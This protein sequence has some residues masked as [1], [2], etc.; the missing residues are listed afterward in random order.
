M[1]TKIIKLKKAALLFILLFGVQSFAQTV[2]NGNVTDASGIPLP[3]ANIVIDGTTTGVASDF[4][5][6][7][8]LSTSEKPPF[9]LKVSSVG[10]ETKSVQVTKSNQTLSIVLNDDNTLDEVIISAS[11]KREKIQEAP[12]A[13]S[14]LTSKKMEA[15]ST[16]NPVMGLKNLTGVDVAQYGVGEGKINLRGKSTAF[17]TETFVIADY[18]NVSIPSLGANQYGQNPVDAIDLDRVEVIKGPGSALYGPGVEAG[19]VHFISKSP[20]KKQGLTFSLGLGNQQQVQAAFRYAEVSKNEKLGFKV[21][22]FVRSAEDFEIDDPEGLARISDDA[23][24]IFSS[25]TGENLGISEIPDYDTK[26]YGFTGTL[27]YKIS[28]KTTLVGTGGYSK[29]EGLIRVGQGEG[30]SELPRPFAQIRL[31]SGGFFAQAFWSKQIGGDDTWLYPTGTTQYNDI[32]QYEGQ[33]QYNFDVLDNKLDL[34]VGTDYRLNITDSKGSLYG[35]FEDDDDYTIYG[36]YLQGKYKATDKVDLIAAGR[37]DRFEA[38]EHTSFSPRL[39]VVYKHDENHTFRA[40]Y[41]H[42]TGAP[43]ALNLF[44]DFQ[45]GAAIG[46]T[47][48]VWLNGGADELTY[49]DGNAYILG[50]GLGAVP[51]ELP[52]AGLYQVVAQ[53]FAGSPLEPYI[54]SLLPQIAASGSTTSP[55][56]FGPVLERGKLEP[57]IS[58]QF[59]IGYNGRVTDKLRVTVDAYYNKR[60]KNLTATVQSSPL[61][62]Y[63]TAGQDL[64]DAIAAVDNSGIILPNGATI[65]QTFQAGLETLTLNADGST[66]VVGFLTAD[67]S[68]NNVID[69][70]FFNIESV[71]YF[72]VDLGLDYALTDDVSLFGNASWISKNYWEEINILGSDQK[73]PFALNVPDLKAKFGVD[74]LPETGFSANVAA[75]YR[76]EFESVNGSSW[77]GTNDASTVVDVSLGYKFNDNYKFNL[78]VTNAFD[79][80]YRP[81]TNAPYV[82]RLIL[83]KLT[84]HI[85]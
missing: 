14:V 72:G 18:R 20:F 33:M 47:V 37:V 70:T 82:G 41:N 51:S 79:Q 9:T 1:K 76:S 27:E 31:Q 84:V 16:A 77:T 49:S 75:R 24:Q 43:V 15:Y 38:L 29:S 45:V 66:A 8:T 7:F 5:G 12:A 50:G 65:A 78:S 13:V 74:Y 54:N 10:F 60:E 61:I 59:E 46:G 35:R 68:P 56:A 85:D 62:G 2:V 21:T 23:T 52:I 53:N 73:V 25:V 6:N 64:H 83:G 26:S 67:Q 42:S 58:N 4:D 30:Y 34:T 44:T 57:S 17:Q 48:P 55:T 39:G 36:A 22:G 71:D 32:S 63:A 80:D 11:R 19:V 81:I 69:L 40:T 3:S 28:D